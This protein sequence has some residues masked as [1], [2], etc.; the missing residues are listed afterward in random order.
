[1]VTAVDIAILLGGAI[2][3]VGGATLSVY[4]VALLGLLLG[5]AAGYL[6]APTVGPMLGLEGLVA[7]A[8]ATGLGIVAGVVL[9]YVLLSVAIAALSFVAGAF[10]GI[11]VLG[12]LFPTLSPFLVYPGAL[13]VGAIAAALGSFMSKTVLVVV[14]SFVGATLLS[15]S[16][17]RAD[18]EAAGTQVSLDPIVFDVASPVFLAL[19]VLG[20]L[21]QF[22]IFKLGYVTKVAAILPGATVLRDRDENTE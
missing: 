7:A 17:T 9:A 10:A 16:V 5:G 2:V 19:F 22:G 4:G 21:V 20:I 13:V 12:A 15:G 6:L 8:A 18:L 3:L 1:M 11:V 14:S